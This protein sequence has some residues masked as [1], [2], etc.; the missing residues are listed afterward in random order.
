MSKVG[1]YNFFLQRNIHSCVDFLVTPKYRDSVFLHQKYVVEGL[2]LAQISAQIFSSK[3]AV[4]KGLRG[5][6]IPIREAHKPHG[7]PSQPKYGYRLRKS[8]AVPARAEQRVID[9]AHSMRDQNLS[10]RAIAKVFTEMKIP[11]KCQGKA[12]H[13]E[14]VKR[15]LTP[16]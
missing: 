10:L 8:R 12:W 11:T 6:G 2:S 7:R 4:S 9:A 15:I 3:A 14:M 1:K 5:A 16:N 13:P